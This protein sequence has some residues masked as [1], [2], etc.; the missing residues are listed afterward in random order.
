MITPTSA[1]SGVS[2][3]NS[4]PLAG[5]SDDVINQNHR[6]QA[7]EHQAEPVEMKDLGSLRTDVGGS[8]EEGRPPQDHQPHEVHFW[9]YFL[10][11]KYYCRKYYRLSLIHI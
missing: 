1:A 4:P 6:G 9:Y 11:Y 10:V 2:S 7:P 5:V 3:K 8:R